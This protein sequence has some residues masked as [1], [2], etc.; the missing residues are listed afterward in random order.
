V[1]DVEGE[2]PSTFDDVVERHRGELYAYC[3]RM[4]GSPHDAEDALQDALIGAWKGYERFEGRSSVRSWL[5]RIATNACLK[6]IERTPQRILTPDFGAAFDQVHD[7]G[8]PQIGQSWLEPWPGSDTSDDPEAAYLRREGV[9]LAFVASLQHLPGTQ[10]AV[11]VLREVLQFSAQETADLLDTTP[12]AA[13]SALQRARNTVQQ[14]ARERSQQQELAD[15]GEDGIREVV[16]RL[17]AAWEAADFD[18]LR[19]QLTADVRFTMPPL[20]AWFAGIEMVGRFFVER[21]FA[22]PWRLVPITANAQ[23]GL[24]CYQDMGDGFRLAAVNV[25]SFRAGLIAHISAFVDPAS[26]ASFGLSERL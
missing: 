14:R 26:Y 21:N 18:A 12:A 15:L 4:L 3:Y 19:E 9:E 20:P 10:R 16:D 25:L 8:A 11:L 22:T 23:P 2:D 5:Y 1:T 7:L 17:V 6:Q 24:A 13:N